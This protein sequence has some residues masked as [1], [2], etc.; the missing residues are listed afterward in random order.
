[1]GWSIRSWLVVLGSF[2]EIMKALRRATDMESFLIFKDFF[3][4]TC[5]TV[6]LAYSHTVEEQSKLGIQSLILCVSHTH[7]QTQNDSVDNKKLNRN[8]CT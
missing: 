8:K 5:I 6:P 2:W 3:L 4:V 7:T 1:M